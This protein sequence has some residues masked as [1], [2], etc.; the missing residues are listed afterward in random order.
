MFAERELL[1]HSRRWLIAQYW[2]VIWQQAAS[3]PNL[4]TTGNCLPW[5]ICAP[6]Q[7]ARMTSDI[8]IAEKRKTITV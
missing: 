8:S 2:S 3:C 4:T 5:R 7:D 1:G 6:A